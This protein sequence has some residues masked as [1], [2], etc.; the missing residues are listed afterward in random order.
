MA[1]S[2]SD[3]AIAEGIINLQSLEMLSNYMTLSA[4]VVWFY[5]FCLTLPT[6]VR[7]IWSRKLT[8]S[9]MPLIF[10]LNRY[11]FML[12]EAMQL[13]SF[14]SK[15][16]TDTRFSCKNL[17]FTEYI[18]GSIAEIAHQLLS[19]LR[20][21][22]LFGQK[23]SLFVLLCLFI[24]ADAIV[25][26]LTWFSYASVTSSQGTLVEPFTACLA[27]NG[28]R[29]IIWNSVRPILQLT[30]TSTIF[31]LTL[32]RTARPI[33]ESRKLVEWSTAK[34]VINAYMRIGTLC[35][36]TILIIAGIQA[37]IMLDSVFSGRVISTKGRNSRLPNLLINR[38]VLNL[39]SYSD[40]TVQHSGNS[41]SDTTAFPLGGLK[42]A[43]NGFIGNMGTGTL[44]SVQWDNLYGV[45][46][47]VEHTSDRHRNREILDRVV[48]P[49][50]T[51]VPVIYDYDKGGP[52]D[53]C[54]WGP[55]LTRDYCTS[56]TPSPLPPTITEQ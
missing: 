56:V 35:F 42:F 5:D 8:G 20:V 50:T 48:D 11:S 28:D 16:M 34:L 13:V 46:N 1:D 17:G 18:V 51:L 3:Q 22:A 41:P 52:R 21:Y 33:M 14:L 23:R 38:F 44:D 30:F 10:I 12:F 24:V 45:S 19:I 31:A 53:T 29:T 7:S 43:E 2:S 54:S 26:S 36:F 15:N 25:G 32:A 40:R 39:R 6:E 55:D 37:A 4:F 47:E 49:L 9:S 27:I